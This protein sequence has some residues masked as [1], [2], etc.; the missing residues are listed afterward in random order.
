[1][2]EINVSST[3]QK[4]IVDTASYSVSVISTG[5]PGPPGPPGNAV[6]SLTIAQR[7]ALT[8]ADLYRGLMIFNIDTGGVE[9]YYGTT[10]GWRPP[11]N[12]AWGVIG[13]VSATGTPIVGITALADLAG[14][15]IAFTAL[16]NRYY[17]ATSY[18]QYTNSA[19]SP[20]LQNLVITNSVNAV[21]GRSNVSNYFT[22]GGN[23]ASMSVI[24]QPFTLTGAQ[25]IKTRFGQGGADAATYTVYGAY[26]ALADAGPNGNAPAL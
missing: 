18:V 23:T 9:V 1:M 3:K 5:L 4:I 24:S 8:G 6:Q 15:I 25:T 16:A 19:G 11:W 2:S 17:V 20:V 7:N 10:T 26:I 13:S 21:I 12:T 14:A 22:A